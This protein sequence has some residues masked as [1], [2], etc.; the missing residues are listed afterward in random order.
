MTCGP[1]FDV[2]GKVAFVTGAGRGLGRSMSAALARAGAD[3][4]RHE[5]RRGDA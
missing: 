1:L 3:L 2:S 4:V 5:P